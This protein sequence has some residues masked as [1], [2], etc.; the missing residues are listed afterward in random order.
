[1][2]SNVQHKAFRQC[3]Q[4]ALQ[5]GILEAKKHEISY[6]SPRPLALV[7]LGHMLKAW[8]HNSARVNELFVFQWLVLAGSHREQV[9]A[10]STNDFDTCHKQTPMFLTGCL[11]RFSITQVYGYLCR[12]V[13][14]KWLDFV[15]ASFIQNGCMSFVDWQGNPKVLS[16]ESQES[17]KLDYEPLVQCTAS[18]NTFIYSKDTLSEFKNTGITKCTAVSRGASKMAPD[19]QMGNDLKEK[20]T[21][22][23]LVR[24]WGVSCC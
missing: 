24:W 8:L 12:L 17:H 16:Y 7:C 9:W 11:Q 2:W 23:V 18:L 4:C 14:Q 22:S 1:M 19:I 20:P 15:F 5:F 6:S 10:A 21:S 3:W 13:Y